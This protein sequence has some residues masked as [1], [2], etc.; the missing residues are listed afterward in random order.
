MYVDIHE[1]S[2]VHVCYLSQQIGSIFDREDDHSPKKTRNDKERK[3]L[4]RNRSMPASSSAVEA[5]KKFQ[6]T[7]ENNL[8]ERRYT[9]VVV[10][11]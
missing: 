6:A 11:V 9:H 10:R 5:R 4:T 7:L 1:V 3:L 8:N 2:L